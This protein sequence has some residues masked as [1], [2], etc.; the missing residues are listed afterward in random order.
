MELEKISD[1]KLKDIEDV[2]TEW[3][4]TS[5]ITTQYE[6]DGKQYGGDNNE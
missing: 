3:E 1:H 5:G 2:V 4:W 6:I